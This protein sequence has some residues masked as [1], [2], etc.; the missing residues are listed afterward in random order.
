MA[1]T[2]PIQGRTFASATSRARAAWNRHLE[3]GGYGRTGSDPDGRGRRK[4]HAAGLDPDPHG[5]GASR[6]SWF[7]C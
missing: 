7:R 1:V 4:R 6:S 3:L 2:L 5:R